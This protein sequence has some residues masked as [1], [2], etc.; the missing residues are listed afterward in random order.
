MSRYYHLRIEVRRYDT[1]KTEALKAALADEDWPIENAEEVSWA[2]SENPDVE[3][4]ILVGD[5]EDS[6]GGDPQEL[7]ERIVHR[8]WRANEG[9]CYVSCWLT[10]IEDAPVDDFSFEEAE[11]QEWEGGQDA[12][13]GVESA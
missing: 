2:T 7:I 6:I 1:K 12:D 4:S 5:R 9:F 13:S 11:Y 8:V 3:E 10:H